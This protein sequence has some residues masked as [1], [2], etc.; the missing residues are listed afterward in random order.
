MR[1]GLRL[2]APVV[3]VPLRLREPVERIGQARLRYRQPGQRLGAVRWGGRFLAGLWPV[4][5]RALTGPAVNGVRVDL[6]TV[7][8]VPNSRQSTG[9][10]RPHNG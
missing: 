7:L 1:E 10:E 8:I 6:P 2:V 4:D 5:I 3:A 9:L